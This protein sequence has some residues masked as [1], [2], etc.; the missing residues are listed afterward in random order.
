M[1][2]RASSSSSLADKTAALQEW[3]D[4]LTNVAS[5]LLSEKQA[6]AELE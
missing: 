4:V 1:A 2:T 3:E 5:Q 6:R